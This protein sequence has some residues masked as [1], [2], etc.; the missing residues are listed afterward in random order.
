MMIIT[1]AAVIFET[2]QCLSITIPE[3]R[4]SERG[5]WCGLVGDMVRDVN[6]ATAVVDGSVFHFD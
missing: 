6:N 1:L 2:F 5:S 3:K 4:K